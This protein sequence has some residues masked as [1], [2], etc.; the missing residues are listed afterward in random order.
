MKLGLEGR[1]ALV[2]GGSRGIGRAIAEALAAEGCRI[3]LCAR[4]AEQVEQAVSDLS[5]SGAHAIGRAVDV[6]DHTALRTWI[7]DAAIELGGIDI[8]V[9]NASAL[10]SSPKADA[11]R[12]ALEVDLLHT[13]T[14][15]ESA[16][17]YLKRSESG[18]IVAIASISGVEDYGYD[19]VAYGA[20]KAALLYYM[21]TLANHLAPQGVRANV[22]SPGTTYFDGGVWQQ[23]ER[24]RPVAFRQALAMNPM[25]RMARPTEIA[26]AVVF[27]AS[28]AASF[29]TGANLVVD[30]GFTRRIQN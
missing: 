14:S 23:I 27:L 7:E 25:G 18:A 22:V 17:P 13:T 16:L 19:D 4:N 11:F 21:K 26:N 3:A 12:R 29:I 30:G 1:R 5:R 15:V 8:L 28:D 20:M 24:D 6:S 2:T 9:A 10:V